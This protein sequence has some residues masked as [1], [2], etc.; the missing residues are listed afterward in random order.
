MLVTDFSIV[1]A[2]GELGIAQ[3]IQKAQV[4]VEDEYHRHDFLGRRDS[5]WQKQDAQQLELMGR[6]LGKEFWRL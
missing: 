1:W 4:P 5:E 2:V 6:Q 3:P